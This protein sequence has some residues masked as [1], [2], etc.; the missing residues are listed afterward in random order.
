ARV[1]AGGFRPGVG[2]IRVSVSFGPLLK[3]LLQEAFRQAVRLGGERLARSGMKRVL[4]VAIRKVAAAVGKMIGQKITASVLK[5]LAKKFAP[6]SWLTLPLEAMT[7]KENIDS[8]LEAARADIQYDIAQQRA[9]LE[10]KI[11]ETLCEANE[12]IAEG[13]IAGL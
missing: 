13:V 12:R 4:Q 8:A 5:Q 3:R 2:A 6:W 11:F 7:L 1:Q 10:H 9:V